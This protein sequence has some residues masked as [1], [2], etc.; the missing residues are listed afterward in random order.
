MKEMTFFEELQWRGLVQDI[1]SPE[2]IEKL[3]EGGLTFYIGTDPTA[4][5]M[6]I[7]HYSSFLI[8]K[9]LAK[10]GHHPI[11]LVGG[12]TGMIGDPKPD[13]ERPMITKEEVD[14]NIKGLTEQAEKIFGFEVVNNWDWTKDINVIDFLRDYGKYFNINYMLAKDKVKSRLETGITFAEF[15]YMILQALDF[16]YLYENRGCTLQVAGSDQ[17]GNITSG[18]ELIRKKIDK[19]AYGMVMPLVTDSTGKK[20]GKTE[21]N[22]L[23]LDKNKTS[24]YEMYQYLINLEDSMIIDYLKKLTFLTP[25]EIMDI[26]KQHNEAPHLRVAHK[27]LAKDI[28]VGLHGEEEFNKAVQISEALFGGDLN[29]LTAEEILLGMKMVPSINISGEVKLIDL[30]VDN[31]IC[32]SRREAREM[33]TSNAISIN[34]EKFTDENAIIE[35]SIAID[36]KVLVIRKGKKK[37][38]I[39]IFE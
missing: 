5:S 17:W 10:H 13:A 8:S 26:E 22:A 6:H 15:S 37:Q 23:W 35:K 16:L 14:K 32:S 24:S 7:G 11:L 2:L 19:E 25:Q 4:D 20:F 27:A 21:G 28:I 39:G 38:F 33:L 3:N 30:L 9:R 29:G 18:I 34:N 12:A 1:S 36:G 31:G